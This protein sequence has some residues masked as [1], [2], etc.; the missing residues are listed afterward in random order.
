[1]KVNNENS[2]YWILKIKW[3]KIKK[4]AEFRTEKKNVFLGIMKWIDFY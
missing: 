3:K 4:K 2:G 1:M